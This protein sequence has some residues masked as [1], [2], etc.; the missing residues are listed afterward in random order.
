MNGMLNILI[1]APP[2]WLPLPLRQQNR[3][4]ISIKG[5][6]VLSASRL[7]SSLPIAARVVAASLSR[8]W[9]WSGCWLWIG[10][11]AG[12]RVFGHNWLALGVFCYR[13]PQQRSA[14]PGT[15]D[16]GP[17]GKASLTHLYRDV[18]A[19]LAFLSYEQAVATGSDADQ[20]VCITVFLVWGTLNP[21]EQLTVLYLQDVRGTLTLTAS[22]Y[23]M[24]APVCGLLMNAAIGLSLPYLKSSIAVPAGCLLSGIAP[25]L[26]ATLCGVDGPGYWRG[27]FQAMALNSLGA[28]LVY[29]IAKLVITDSF[30]AKTQALAGGVFNMLAQVGKSVGIATSA[31]IARQITSQMDHAESATAMLKG[32]EAGWWYNCGLG[33]VS[34][35]VSFGGMRSVKVIEIKRD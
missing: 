8:P 30:P 9:W 16:G 3:L 35:A 17:L 24:P 33:F 1:E 15:V 18:D 12:R 19:C 23:F 22:L 32:Y 28:D 21:S 10:P 34:V 20:T 7:T 11:R 4:R 26:L 14:G 29:T 13:D 25:L 2:A 6:K 31:L 5:W 27:V